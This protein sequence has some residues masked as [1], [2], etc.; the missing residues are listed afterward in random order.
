MDKT[1]GN[2]YENENGPIDRL[3][4]RSDDSA[5]VKFYTGEVIFYYSSVEKLIVTEELTGQH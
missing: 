4:V 2:L 3:T 1:K 5:A